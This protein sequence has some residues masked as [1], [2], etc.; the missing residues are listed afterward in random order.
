MVC[1]SL[2]LLGGA[3]INR[4]PLTF[5]MRLNPPDDFLWGPE[6]VTSKLK[7]AAEGFTFWGIRIFTAIVFREIKL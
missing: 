6:G 3:M 1:K 7:Q 2:F 5:Q 4:A